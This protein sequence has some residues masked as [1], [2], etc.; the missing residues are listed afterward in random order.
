MKPW[1]AILA[2]AF[3]L[4]SCTATVPNAAERSASASN[5]PVRGQQLEVSAYF[6]AAG[7]RID[8][9][10]AEN[11]PTASDRA[12]VPD[13]T[14]PGVRHVVR[15]RLPALRRALLDEK[16]VDSPRHGFSTR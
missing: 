12:H 7:D 10:V 9:E 11:A 8:L 3:L 16:H 5:R 13:G 4:V 15:L 2:I 1:Q 6:E 14:Q